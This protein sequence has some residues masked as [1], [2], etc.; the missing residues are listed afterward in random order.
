[1]L[2]A[3]DVCS[4][5][6]ME[7]RS[8]RQIDR[9]DVTDNGTALDSLDGLIPHGTKRR[10]CDPLTAVFEIIKPAIAEENPL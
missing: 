8:V 4:M 2:W 6:S 1:M 9:L 7:N 3:G 5:F 10:D